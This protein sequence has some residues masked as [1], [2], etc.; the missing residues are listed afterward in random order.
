MSSSDSVPE[1]AESTKANDDSTNN[2]SHP[3]SDTPK[4]ETNNTSESKHTENKSADANE[5]KGK[6]PP[7]QKI[8]KKE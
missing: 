7:E 3:P 1:P 4:K 8:S 6:D 5:D 2:T